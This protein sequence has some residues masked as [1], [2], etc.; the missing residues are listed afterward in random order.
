VGTF[1]FAPAAIG[2]GCALSLHGCE[3]GPRDARYF[4]RH[5]QSQVGR[6]AGPTTISSIA[7]EGNALVVTL[8][9]EIG[10]RRGTPSYA[11]TA[12]FLEGFC[13]KPDVAVY[14]TEGRTLR[15]DSLEKGASAIRGSPVERCPRG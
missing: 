11:I 9:G 14:F 8:D 1:R 6:T 7:A 12:Y 10:W 15:V 4:A 3:R 2:L 5:M 13:K